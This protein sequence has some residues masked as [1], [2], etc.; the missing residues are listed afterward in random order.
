[1]SVNWDGASYGGPNLNI[2]FALDCEYQF[3]A[4]L[5]PGVH[6]TDLSLTRNLSFNGY[7]PHG[8]VQILFGKVSPRVRILEEK[9]WFSYGRGALVCGF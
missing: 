3:A 6:C 9:V 5:P 4:H 7:R 8:W 2:A 1:M